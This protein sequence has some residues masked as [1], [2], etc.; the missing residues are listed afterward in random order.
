MNNKRYGEE[1]GHALLRAP[2]ERGVA[3]I[4]FVLCLVLMIEVAALV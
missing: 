3:V 1:L 4:Q 2:H